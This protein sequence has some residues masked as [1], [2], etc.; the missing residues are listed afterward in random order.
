M[1]NEALDK[2]SE[3]DPETNQD[4]VAVSKSEA[5]ESLN[6][7]VLYLKQKNVNVSEIEILRKI[8]FRIEEDEKRS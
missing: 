4:R 1:D 2:S 7:T 3:G 5:L 6:T 8:K